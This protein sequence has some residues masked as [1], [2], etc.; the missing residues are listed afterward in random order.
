MRTC[1]KAATYR[2]GCRCGDCRRAGV[3]AS[4]RW[5]ERTG[6]VSERRVTVAPE[7]RPVYPEALCATVPASQ[8]EWWF[9]NRGST[10]GRRQQDAAKTICSQCPEQVRCATWAINHPDEIGIWGGLT[11]DERHTARR[12]A[13]RIPDGS[14]ACPDCGKVVAAG[15]LDLHI[16][17]SRDHQAQEA[18]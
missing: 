2:A 9:A 1:G 13:G 16:A 12:R 8:R 3:E 7:P 17:R 14:V 18:S 10:E 5:R 6:R 4:R 11:E 15:Y